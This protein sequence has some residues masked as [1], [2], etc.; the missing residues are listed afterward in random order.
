MKIPRP[1]WDNSPEAKQ[2]LQDWKA[3]RAETDER[4]PWL[5]PLL[6]GAA[7]VVIAVVFLNYFG[8]IRF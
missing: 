8:V 3:A 2:K 1:R 4:K 7:V 5:L 6:I